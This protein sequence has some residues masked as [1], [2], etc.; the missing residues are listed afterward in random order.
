MT[1]IGTTATGFCGEG[2]RL[3]STPNTAWPSE[4]LLKRRGVG[5]RGWKVGERKHLG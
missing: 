2:E 4:T 3:S 1:D 5:V